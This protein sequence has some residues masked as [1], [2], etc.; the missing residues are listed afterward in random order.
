M[1]SALRAVSVKVE[2]KRCSGIPTKE[3]NTRVESIGMNAHP[4]LYVTRGE[5]LVLLGFLIHFKAKV[6]KR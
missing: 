6:V 2:G 3:Q 1:N 5:K 4:R